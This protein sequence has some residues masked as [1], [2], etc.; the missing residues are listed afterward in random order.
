MTDLAALIARIKAARR[1]D[2]DINREL[3]P[4]AGL[5]IVDEGHPIGRACYDQNSHGVPLPNFT[6]SIDAALTLVPEGAE[7][8]VGRTHDNR[9]IACIWVGDDEF[10]EEGETPALSL[11]AAALKARNA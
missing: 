6:G 9:G 11:C 7:F 8:A 3:A 1:A 2:F 4:L 5:R 10:S